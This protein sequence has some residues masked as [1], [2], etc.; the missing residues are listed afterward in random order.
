MSLQQ[1]LVPTISAVL[2]EEKNVCTLSIKFSSSCGLHYKNITIINDTSR[3]ARIT[4]I[5]HAP[6]CGIT[7]HSDNS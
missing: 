3:V 5:S 4:I 7:C 6:G 1:K 2:N